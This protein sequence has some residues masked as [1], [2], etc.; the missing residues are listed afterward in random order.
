MT[1]QR[2]LQLQCVSLACVVAGPV[3]LQA[4]K[5]T[6]REKKEM[7]MSRRKLDEGLLCISHSKILRRDPIIC[8]V[9]PCL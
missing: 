6:A 9:L 2:T 4:E 5:E 1:L 8:A 3:L 7:S